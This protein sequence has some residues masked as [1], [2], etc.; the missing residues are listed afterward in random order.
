MAVLVSLPTSYCGNRVGS[1]HARVVRTARG[2]RRGPGWTRV[3]LYGVYVARV[4]CDLLGQRQGNH[5]DASRM[6]TPLG[7]TSALLT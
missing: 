6:T 3:G 1:G 5:T 4:Q 7:S 2:T